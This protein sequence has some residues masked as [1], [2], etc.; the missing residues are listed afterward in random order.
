MYTG[1]PYFGFG[2]ICAVLVCSFPVKS[3]PLLDFT[4]FNPPTTDQRKIDNPVMS[5]LV[6]PDPKS[7]CEKA[8]PK[9][10]YFVRP[11]GCVYWLVKSSSCTIVTTSRTT[12]SQL[13]HL[14]VRCMQAQ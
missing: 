14:F 2:A 3:D 6:Q 11:E 4:L 12:H 10:G 1:K 7:T 5:W 8:I 9:D 13:G